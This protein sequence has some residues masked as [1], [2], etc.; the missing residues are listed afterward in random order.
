MIN[1]AGLA[2][3][4]AVNLS[5]LAAARKGD[6][7]DRSVGPS[8]KTVDGA[9]LYVLEGEYEIAYGDQKVRHSGFVC[10]RSGEL[11]HTLT[12]IRPGQARSLGTRHRQLG[13]LLE[14]S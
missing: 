10:F 14:G 13:R 3:A 1:I 11:A 7:V 9:A 8:Q 12:A 5:F 2:A 6:D 4:I